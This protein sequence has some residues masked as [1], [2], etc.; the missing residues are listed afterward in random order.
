MGKKDISLNDIPPEGC[1]IVVDDAAVWQEPMQEFGMDCRVIEPLRAELQ[2]VP[3]SGGVLVR[4]M[5]TGTVVQPCDRCAEDAPFTL[6]HTIDT[7]ESVPHNASAQDVYAV[8]EEDEVDST[9]AVESHIVIEKNMAVL[10]LADLCWEEF[11]LVLP[12]RPLCDVACK[13]LCP[14]CGINRNKGTCSC[15]ESIQD[16]RLA[17]LR[18]WGAKNAK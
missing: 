10:R 2:L 8:S 11:M 13:G 14:S 18:Q 3:L 4:G 1:S 15:V 7:F 9:E 17:A 16:S 6:A 5:L 12:M